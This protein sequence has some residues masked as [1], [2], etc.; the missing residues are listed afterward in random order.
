MTVPSFFQLPVLAP[1]DAQ[2]RQGTRQRGIHRRDFFVRQ[3]LA[4]SRFRPP[5]RFFRLSARRKRDP[6]FIAAKIAEQ[7]GRFGTAALMIQYFSG[8]N[9]RPLSVAWSS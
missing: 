8:T 5:P 6:T 2:L 7:P 4:K 9:F 3:L 1:L